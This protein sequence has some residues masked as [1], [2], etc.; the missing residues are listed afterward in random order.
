[1]ATFEQL[2]TD[3]LHTQ[4]ALLKTRL[5]QGL[6]LVR[7]GVAERECAAAVVLADWSPTPTDWSSPG[8]DAHWPMRWCGC[9]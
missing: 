2:G 8:A 9:C 3:A 7:V 1:V 5:R 6:P 4:D